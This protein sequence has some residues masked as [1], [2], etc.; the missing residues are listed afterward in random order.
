MSL[1]PV[2]VQEAQPSWACPQSGGRGSRPGGSHL[3]HMLMHPLCRVGVQSG[4]ELP[5]QAIAL[6]IL[7]FGTAYVEKG[8]LSLLGL[9]SIF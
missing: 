5:W 7:P 3:P 8:P 2:V 6:L 9:G 1:G 4:M